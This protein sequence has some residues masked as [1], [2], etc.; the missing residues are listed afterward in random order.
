MAKTMRGVCCECQSEGPVTRGRANGVDEDG[1][2]DD[3]PTPFSQTEYGKAGEY[4]MADHDAFGPPCEGVGTMP[5]AV[6]EV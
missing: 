6:Y 2:F 4:V 5:Q 3:T 1:D